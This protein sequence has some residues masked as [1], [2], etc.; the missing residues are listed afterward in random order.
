MPS[1]NRDERNRS[2]VVSDLLDEARYL[3]GN[4]LKPGL[5]VRG[6]GGVHLVTGNN[7]LLHTQGVGEKS[8]LPSLAVL[9]D[10]SLKLTDT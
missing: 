5:A 6:L 4:L 2:R 10:A 3:L 8:M 7:E 1:R 9:G